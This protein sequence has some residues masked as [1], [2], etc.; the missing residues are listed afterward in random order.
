M[1]RLGMATAFV[2]L[3]VTSAAFAVMPA[4]MREGSPAA[5]NII[6]NPMQSPDGAVPMSLLRSSQ[7]Y[8]GVDLSDVA[9]EQLSAL[10]LKEARGA[11]IITVDHDGPA[12]KAG[13]RERDVVLQMNGQVIEGKEQLRRMLH[14]TPAGHTVNFVISRDGQQQNVSVQLANRSE[15]ERHAWEQ[16]FSVPQPVEGAPPAGPNTANAPGGSGFAPGAGAQGAS[17]SSGFAS[18]MGNSFMGPLLSLH[19]SYTGVMLDNLGPQLADYFG[20]KPGTGLLVK[21]VD[22]NS[23]AATAGLKAGDVVVKVNAV[24][25][26]SPNDWLK[27]MREHKGKPVQVTVLRNK[28]EQTLTL[29]PSDPKK[30]SEMEPFELFDGVDAPALVAEMMPDLDT[31]REQAEQLRQQFASPEFQSEIQAQLKSQMATIREDA[32]KQAAE[33]KQ[34]M[35]SP[36]F[37]QQMEDARRQAEE[38]RKQFDT[39]E[40]IQKMQQMQDQIRQQ[41][42]L[43]Q[44]TN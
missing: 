42:E 5:L 34:L 20:A 15:V 31:L 38:V 37:K 27:T 11:E 14:E 43:I 32:E 24:A 2:T 4:P 26:T 28:Q 6:M 36:E 25:V 33:A 23:P 18:H 35:D 39:P 40:F 44:L 30:K 22:A 19:S 12:A 8:L 17:G 1:K 16:H 9:D 41:M 29:T 7:G 10:K 13:L 21:S 3:A